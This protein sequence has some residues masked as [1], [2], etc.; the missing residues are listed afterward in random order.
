MRLYDTY[1][2][3]L[4]ELP[5][6]PGPVRMYFCGPTVYARAHIGNARPFV[7]GMWLRS[8][9]RATGYDADARPQHHRRQRQDLRRRAER[10]RGAR[11]ARDRLVPRGHRRPRARDARLP[12]EGHR[13][14]PGDRPLHRAARRGR[15]RLPGRGRRLLPRRALRRVRA[16]LG[17]A[18]RPGRGAGAEPAQGGPARL[19]A[20]EGEQAR[21]GHA[22]GLAVGPG[23][24]GLAH[25]VL[26]DGGGAARPDASRSTAAGSTSSSRITRTR[27]PSRA[28]SATGSRDIWVAQ[29]DSPARRRQ[30]VEV[31]REHRLDP[32]GARP[33]GPRDGARLLPRRPLAQADR[34]LRRDDGA[35][36]RT[37]GGVP[38]R[39]PRPERARRRLGRVRGGARR[40][41]QHAGGARAD[42]RLARPR[43]AAP[44]ARGLRARLARRPRRGP[45]RDRRARRAAGSR[46]GPTATSSSPTGS[47]REIEAAGW[48]MRDEAGGY[49][50]VRRR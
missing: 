15:L 46:R 12:A 35:G 11:R 4:V 30:D 45:A 32:G 14:H 43:P 2:R 8:W 39:L 23:P 48:E 33:V 13:A 42:A 47:A 6:P 19:R 40:R 49:T 34:V 1:S 7:I 10:E 5:A 44:R 3:S 25:R 16:A 50:L 28:R 17:P 36:G 27:S 20:L 18:A 38:Q 24:A 41:L 22:L 37:G 26:G 9:L 21:R 29:R 31:A